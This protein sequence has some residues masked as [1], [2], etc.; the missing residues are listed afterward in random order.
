MQLINSGRRQVLEQII[1][2]LATI[3]DTAEESFLAYYDI[4]MPILKYVMKNAVSKDL[5]L[6]RGKTIECIS[7]IGLAVGHEKV[8]M[9]TLAAI[10]CEDCIT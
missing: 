1:T 2:T 3:A 4:F 6:L 5:R 10:V 8:S 9:F 7:L